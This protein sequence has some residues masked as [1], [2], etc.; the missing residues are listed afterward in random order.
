MGIRLKF[1]IIKNEGQD[2]LSILSFL[3]LS[4]IFVED[5]QWFCK[6]LIGLN[7]KGKNQDSGKQEIENGESG[8]NEKIVTVFQGNH[9]LNPS[10]APKYQP[11]CI[12]AYGK[13][14]F[15]ELLKILVQGRPAMKSQD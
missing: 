9:V 11:H 3:L 10:S 14:A 8:W 4:V 5:L 13:G 7:F 6:R 1:S 2:S 15:D 12:Y